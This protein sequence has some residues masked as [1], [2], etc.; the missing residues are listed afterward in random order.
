MISNYEKQKLGMFT[1]GIFGMRNINTDTQNIIDQI[2]S[3]NDQSSIFGGSLDFSSV[4]QNMIT[5]IVGNT[6]GY[7]NSLTNQNP[8]NKI[9]FGNSQNP[10]DINSVLNGY[11]TV[12]NS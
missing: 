5:N 9:L 12:Q 7:L 10:I 6:A 1:D 11:L 4:S 8:S 3:I 2:V